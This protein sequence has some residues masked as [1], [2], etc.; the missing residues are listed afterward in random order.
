MQIYSAAR[1]PVYKC[2]EPIRP[3]RYA[4]LLVACV[5]HAAAAVLDLRLF[6]AG[7]PPTLPHRQ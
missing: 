3:R 4:A 2:K 6:L 1:A 5:Q 7:A